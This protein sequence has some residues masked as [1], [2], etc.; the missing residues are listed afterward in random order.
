MD[1]TKMWL[2]TTEQAKEWKQEKFE[3]KF[4]IVNYHAIMQETMGI[5][6]MVAIHYFI[7]KEPKY[8]P[9]LNT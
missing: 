2:Q 1:N 7:L 3:L 8:K 5:T 4:C 9:V 6:F